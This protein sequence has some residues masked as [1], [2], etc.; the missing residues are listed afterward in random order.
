MFLG[1]S[2]RWYLTKDSIEHKIWH[3]KALV[4]ITCWL[5]AI[6]LISLSLRIYKIKITVSVSQGCCEDKMR[7]FIY[8]MS[9][10]KTQKHYQ[11]VRI[12]TLTVLSIVLNALGYPGIIFTVSL[13][14]I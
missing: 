1:E 11:N 10:L 3:Q 4:S 2:R 5:W 8:T 14:P 12:I 6:F 7:W 13:I 9:M